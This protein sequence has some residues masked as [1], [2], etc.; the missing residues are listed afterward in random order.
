MVNIEAKLAARIRKFTPKFV[1]VEV[2][3]PTKYT[4]KIKLSPMKGY[5]HFFEDTTPEEIS[6]GPEVIPRTQREVEALDEFI[7]R[8]VESYLRK[9]LKPSMLMRIAD[10][11][12]RFGL[13]DGLQL[14]MHLCQKGSSLHCTALYNYFATRV[15][16]DMINTRDM[17]TIRTII[18]E[19]EAA[20]FDK[21]AEFFESLEQPMA[22]Y[23]PKTIPRKIGAAFTAGLKRVLSR[24]APVVDPTTAPEE[25]VEKSREIMEKNVTKDIYE[26]IDIEDVDEIPIFLGFEKIEDPY[27]QTALRKVPQPEIKKPEIPEKVYEEEAEEVERLRARLRELMKELEEED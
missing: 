14:F 4:I 19:L 17:Y 18:E 26:L 25:I 9:K 11:I 27:V 23:A 24:Y 20:G 16:R 8:F 22:I 3:R 1:N 10:A 21:T 5:E 12:S 7:I 2:T 6:L 13:E 15:E